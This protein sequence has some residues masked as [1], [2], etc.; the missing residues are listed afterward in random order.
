M[1]GR[2]SVPVSPDWRWC[3]LACYPDTGAH[4][5]AGKEQEREGGGSVHTLAK[6]KCLFIVC[7]IGRHGDR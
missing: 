4:L 2:Y 7:Y 3:Y 1:K 5:L 6:L